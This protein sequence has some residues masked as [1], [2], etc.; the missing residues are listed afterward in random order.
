MSTRRARTRTTS[1]GGTCARVGTGPGNEQLAELHRAGV[2]GACPAWMSAHG[3]RWQPPLTGTLHLG[4]TNRFFLG[5]GKA[6]VN[7]YYRTA[8]RLGD[9]GLLR[10]HGRGPG[11]G[12]RPVH[13][14]CCRRGRRRPI[15][16][17]RARSWPRAAASRP[18]SSGCAGT[19]ATPRT[20]TSSAAAATTTAGC[21]A[22]L[23]E[24]GAARAGEE[25]GFH[26]VAVDARS[27]RFDGG[28]ATRLDSIPF[29][30]VVNRD[31]ERFY[32]EGEDLWPKRYAIWGRN[33]R[34]AARPDRLLDLGREGRPA[35]SCRRCTRRSQADSDRRA[36]G[37]GSALTPAALAAT[38][39]RVQ[40]ARS[41]R[42]Q[43]DPPA[44]TTAAPTGS[45]R[46]RAT[47]RSRSTPRRSTASRCARASRSRTSASRSTRRRGSCAGRHGVAQRV[48]GGRDHVRQHPLARLPGRLRPDDRHRLRPDRRAGGAARRA[49]LRW[50]SCSPRRSGS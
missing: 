5:G 21:C 11:H 50:T 3:V 15:R 47:G 33:Y 29:G 7:T 9:R 41:A 38:V 26:A 35:R 44:W 12:G 25:R 18:T 37:V 49:Q 16:S 31:G 45:A 34:R 2:R 36:R 39:D 43:F 6:L 40:R 24:H 14:P 17:P 48:R 46:R 8:Q 1:C 10:H 19:G 22:A 13:R 30:I 27:P 4:R 28:I 20:T 23:Y 32:D 42:R